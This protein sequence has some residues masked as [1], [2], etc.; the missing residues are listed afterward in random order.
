MPE[1]YELQH[2]HTKAGNDPPADLKID[3]LAGWPGL[4]RSS[5][6]QPAVRTGDSPGTQTPAPAPAPTTR[7]AEN[8]TAR[9]EPT[10]NPTELDPTR[11]NLLGG[12]PG[13]ESRQPVARPTDQTP[14][15]PVKNG[16]LEISFNDLTNLNGL[17]PADAPYST[18]K[19]NR[20]PQGVQ[21]LHWADESG[22]YFFFQGAGEKNIYHYPRALRIIDLDGQRFD[23]DRSRLKVNEY[24]LAQAA[25]SQDATKNPFAT[26]TNPKVDAITYFKNMSSLS[27][28]ALTWQED[29]LR[30]GV[31]DSKNP[32]FQIYLADV[33]TMQAM[34]PLVRGFL[35]QGQVSP[36]QKQQIL[37][38]LD[39]ADR[40]LQKAAEMSYN[41]LYQMNRFPP[42]NVV[43]PL[44]PEAQF[45]IP[46]PGV[47]YDPYYAYWGGSWDQAQRRRTAVAFMKG[48]IQSNVFKYFELPP[49]MAPR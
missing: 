47:H 9:S 14:K 37:N 44:A 29:L 13:L 45:Y 30:K 48:L 16:I 49:A 2:T 22:Y 46:P 1:Q 25:G 32:Y 20:V 11:I 38:K 35:Q 23:I 34:Q 15:Y 19:I 5:S 21:I 43:M 12:W 17:P 27:G 4:S 10:A 42:G 39:D 36:E 8:T 7:P 6:G 24:A 28:Q 40:Q 3:L 33:L 41:P 26:V 18:L 31:E